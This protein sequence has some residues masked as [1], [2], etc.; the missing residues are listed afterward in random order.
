MNLKP[1]IENKGA[2]TFLS[3]SAGRGN[4]IT[5][6]NVRA[7]L[8]RARNPIAVFMMKFLRAQNASRVILLIV[9]FALGACASTR[10][11][12]GAG[13]A[14][15]NE[16]A[17]TAGTGATIAR[18]WPD[19]RSA[20]S[21]DRI[22]EYFTGAENT[23]NQIVLR[24]H[25]ESRDGFYFFTRLKMES[26]A[27]IAIAGASVEIGV[28]MPGTPVA[29]TFRL[30]VPAVLRKGTVLLNPGLTGPDW[31]PPDAKT[32]PVA[33]R[34]RLLAADGAVLASAQS[35]LWSK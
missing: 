10:G 22:S 15:K 20:E 18:V 26:P 5:D 29:K 9:A 11:G 31:P 35:Y 7:P 28:I 30:R 3:V 2:R 6:R 14:A 12:G 34:V 21:F 24:T 4:S 23:G 8:L 27:D 33:W 17:G 25:P 1:A 19:Y 13:G 32:Q 16:T